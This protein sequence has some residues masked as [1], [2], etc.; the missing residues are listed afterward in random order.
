MSPKTKEQF[1]E[2]RLQT[3]TTIKEVALELFAQQGYHGTSI[4]QIARAAN[5]S[6]GLMYNYFSGK[7]ELLEAI[8]MDA[9]NEGEQLMVYFLELP[10]TPFSKLKAITEGVMMMVQN[11]LKHWKLLTSLGM[12]TFVIQKLKG[13]LR[14]KTINSM[15][16]A[17]ALFK[18]MGVPDPT[19]EAFVYGAFLDGVL[20]HYL[21]MTDLELAYP[22]QKML[23]FIVAR[24]EQYNS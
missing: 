14:Q 24:Y 2:I 10:G 5:I 15:E 17:E 13:P 4:S 19:Q 23:E 18:E 12:Q 7:E 3:M 9:V 22:L 16:V 6:K 11:D 20:L 8:V 1:D 21:T